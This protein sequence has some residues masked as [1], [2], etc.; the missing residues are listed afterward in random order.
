MILPMAPRRRE[1]VLVLLFAFLFVVGVSTMVLLPDPLPRPGAVTW[2]PSVAPSVVALRVDAG[3]RGIAEGS[4][5]VVGCRQTEGLWE[6]V[7]VTAAHVT[8]AGPAAMVILPGGA[9]VVSS[10][11][12]RHESLDVS[13]VW[14]PSPEW[15]PSVP[16]R[17]EPA[18]IGERC[19]SFGFGGDLGVRWLSEGL[20]C[21]YGAATAQVTYGDSGGAVLDSEG[22]LLG[23]IAALERQD[24]PHAWGGTSIVLAHHLL[25]VPCPE[26]A[27]WARQR[28]GT[29]K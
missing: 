27:P 10:R 4:G 29:E 22:C 8:D 24:D 11:I 28:A 21:D 2:A 12:D 1:N 5:V 9:V 3:A 25:F 6:V 19:Y 13:L 14:A 26:W 15:V 16:I 20:V 17:S 7:I 18:E 23:V